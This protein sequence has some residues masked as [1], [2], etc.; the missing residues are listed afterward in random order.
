MP[1]LVA[2]FQIHFCNCCVWTLE[3]GKAEYTLPFDIGCRDVIE[4]FFANGVAAIAVDGW[5]KF[6]ETNHGLEL[7]IDNP[8][9]EDLK[10]G[11]LGSIFQMEED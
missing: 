5:Q 2:T 7:V 6:Y 8:E 3:A 11:W 4:I 1:T 10:Y 9:S